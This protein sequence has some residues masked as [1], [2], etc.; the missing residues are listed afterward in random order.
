MEK[1]RKQGFFAALKEEVVRGLSPASSRGKSPAPPRSA[2]PVRMLVPRRSKAPAAPPPPPLSE[3]VLQQYLGEQL[4]ARSGSLR[5][6]GEALAPLIEGPEAERLAVGD[7][8]AEDSGRR[9]GFG[10]WVY[11]HLT[12]TPSMASSAAAAAGGPG[13]SSGSLFHAR[14]SPEPPLASSP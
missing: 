14:G 4:V 1:E 10:H 8:D 2:S 3:K 5:L 13:G 6:G 7:P 9:E 11:G 12:R